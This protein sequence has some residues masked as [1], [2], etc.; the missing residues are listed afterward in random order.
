[1]LYNIHDRYIG[2]C[3][4][5]YGEWSWEEIRATQQYASGTVLD[6]GANIGTHTLAYSHVAKQVVA[7]EPVVGLF[8][9]L[10]TNL[11]LNCM[12]N[13]F[14]VDCAIGAEN[15][16]THVISPDYQHE[17]NLGAC[18]IGD[19]H[20]RTVGMRT[21]DSFSFPDVSLIKIDVEGYEREVLR[22]AVET[23]KRCKPVLYVE[24]D[25]K[26]KSQDLR[27][28]I[29]SIGYSIEEHNVPL[30]NPQNYRDNAEN[31]FPEIYSTNLL[32][33]PRG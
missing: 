25:R 24:D 5:L 26:E 17:N 21:I 18:T 12:E 3:L 6:I 1:M 32:C 16:I 7:F 27:A 23:I 13:V 8:R 22:G 10:C 29:E 11:A 15:A 31:V 30:Y 20:W 4:D 28:F 2:R 14:P 33:L 9:L 19:E